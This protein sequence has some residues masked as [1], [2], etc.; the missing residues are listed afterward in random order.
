MFVVV[1]I[2]FLGF[3][4]KKYDYVSIGMIEKTI[5]NGSRYIELEI[6]DKDLKSNTEPVIA[7]GDLTTRQITSQNFLDCNEVFNMINTVA[8]SQK[9]INNFNDPLFIFLNI[10]TKK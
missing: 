4:K 2:L 7:V 1:L 3:Q 10:K 8:F 6:L 9:Y 5:M